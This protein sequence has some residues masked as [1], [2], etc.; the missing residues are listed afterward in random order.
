MYAK[1]LTKR[2]SKNKKTKLD[3]QEKDVKIP[4]NVCMNEIY[5]HCYNGKVYEIAVLR[6]IE[7]WTEDFKEYTKVYSVALNLKKIR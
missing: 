2:Y 3:F 7:K 1:F 4:D 5:M 6:W